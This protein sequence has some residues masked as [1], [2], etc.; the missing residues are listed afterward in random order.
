[1]EII[2]AENELHLH[3]CIIEKQHCTKYET[4]YES[5]NSIHVICH[6]I[7]LMKA[8]LKGIMHILVEK[9]IYVL[10]IM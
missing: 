4:M 8:L 3:C 9:Y 6:G 5:V 1:M 10:Y 2:E 7:I